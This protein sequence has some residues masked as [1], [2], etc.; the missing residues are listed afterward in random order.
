LVEEIDF[1]LKES[2]PLRTINEPK[3]IEAS[4]L[5]DITLNET[6]TR[7][8]TG[9]KQTDEVFGGGI[10]SGSVILL[11]GDPGIGKSTMLTQIAHNLS[12]KNQVLYLSAEES[13][14]QVCLRSKR[15]KLDSKNIFVDSQQNVL[16]LEKLLNQHDVQFLIVDSIQSM[17]HP[18][19]NSAPGSVSQVRECA[20]FLVTTAKTKG[21]A[22]IIVGHVTK[23][24]SIAGPRVLEHMVDVV[25]YFEGDK[26]RQLRILRSKKNRFGSTNEISILAMSENGL[27]EV[28]NPSSLF[29]GDRL[30]G[31]TSLRVPSGCAILSIAE[32]NKSFLVEVQSLSGISALTSPRRV[33][34]GFDVNRLQLIL[35]VLEKRIGLPLARQD[36]YINVVGG[37]EFSDPGGDLGVSIAIATSHF[38]RSLDPFVVFI[39]EIGLTGE[40]RP[41]SL[42]EKR[43]KEAQSMGF[44]KAVVPKG[45]LP[46]QGKFNGLEIVGI[47]YLTEALHIAMPNLESNRTLQKQSSSD[48]TSSQFNIIDNSNVGNR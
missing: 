8:T 27:K 47:E 6:E 19:I 15:L 44:K 9:L 12:Y 37:F 18:L 23:D 33:A 30:A 28:D 4:L 46:T 26:S 10:V 2:N 29:I 20:S 43:L 31:K 3:D 16:A 39:G 38:D 34:N 41:V 17:Y 22:T 48:H 24:G 35:A 11:A 36:V 1:E 7:Y 25:L 21:I 5:S 32:G 45:N 42:I 13:K 14:Q 40:I